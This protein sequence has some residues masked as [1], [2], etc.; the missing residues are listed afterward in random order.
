MYLVDNKVLENPPA[1]T[2]PATYLFARPVPGSHPVFLMEDTATGQEI[3]STDLYRFVPSEPLTLGIPQ[4]HPNSEYY[5]HC[6]RL[7]SRQ[8]PLPLETTPRVLA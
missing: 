2:E 8:K 1:G 6:P 5:K 3:I 4:E 7:L